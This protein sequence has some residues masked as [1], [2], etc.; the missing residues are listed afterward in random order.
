MPKTVLCW[1]KL[2]LLTILYIRAAL[3]EEQSVMG[4]DFIGNVDREGMIIDIDNELKN[5]TEV[6]Y[7][8]NT[9]YGSMATGD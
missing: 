1:T 7:L 4:E 2:K 9:W 3:M 8:G 6:R 5:R